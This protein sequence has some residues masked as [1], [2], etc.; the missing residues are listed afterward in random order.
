MSISDRQTDRWEQDTSDVRREPWG[1]VS[2]TLGGGELPM[3][4]KEV[5]ELSPKI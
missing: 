1:W 5:R 4:V 3:E 2:V